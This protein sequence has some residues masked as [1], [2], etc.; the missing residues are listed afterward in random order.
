LS[1]NMIASA[2]LQRRSVYAEDD[3]LRTDRL[4][5]GQKMSGDG[6]KN[7][8]L[9]HPDDC[10][11]PAIGMSVGRSV[12]VQLGRKLRATYDELLQQT[13]PEKFRQLLDELERREKNP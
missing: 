9:E 1:W 7:G 4:S 2:A 6:R 11:R 12:Q 13:V 10:G 3:P 8:L 5:E